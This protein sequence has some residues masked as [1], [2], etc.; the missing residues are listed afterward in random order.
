[1][2]T[3]S[4]NGIVV[5]TEHAAAAL[6]PTLR[7]A[8]PLGPSGVHI[9]PTWLKQ[10][11]ARANRKTRMARALGVAQHYPHGKLQPSAGL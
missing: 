3:A 4:G 6:A 2:V 8:G 5:F 9:R 7:N 11:V 10:S 1:M